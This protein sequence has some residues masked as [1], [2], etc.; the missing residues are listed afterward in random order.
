MKIPFLELKPTYDELR[1]QLDR[2]Y[3]RVMESGWYL[4]GA[5]LKGLKPSSRIIAKEDTQ[6]G[7][8]MDWTPF[9]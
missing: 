6:S 1:P 5:E 3:H 8:G 2:A 7:L 4:L 9:I